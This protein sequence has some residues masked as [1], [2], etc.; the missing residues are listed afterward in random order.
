VTKE[1]S[2]VCEKALIELSLKLTHPVIAGFL[3]AAVIS[4]IL[5]T[6]SSQLLV[7]ASAVSYDLVEVCFGKARDDRRSL[8]L[9]RVVVVLVGVIGVLVALR[10]ESVI[11]WFV[12]FAWSGL[13]ASFGPLMLMSLGKKGVN[14]YGALACMLTGT[15]VT[16]VWKL[17]VQAMKDS[18]KYG[19]LLQNSWFFVIAAAVLILVA[20]RLSGKFVV[21]HVAAV[22]MAL[23]LTEC[24]WWAVQRSGLWSL[25]ELVPAFLLATVAAF[26]VSGFTEED[27]E[28]GPINQ[29]FSLRN[30]SL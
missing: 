11:F 10:G 2:G 14:R 29:H 30:D 21:G 25:Y 17:G 18:E 13:G 8:M 9:G 20:G 4:A 3:L 26:V 19:S 12:L 1:K 16:V 28:T 22:L 27:E 24:A 15:G 23:I 6:V 7:A 5:S